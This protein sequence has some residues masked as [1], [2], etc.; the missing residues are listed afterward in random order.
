MTHDAITTSTPIGEIFEKTENGKWQPAV[1]CE[2]ADGSQAFQHAVE[3]FREW[4]EKQPRPKI[5]L[6]NGWHTITPELAE[7]LLICNV[8][9]RKLRWSEVYRYATSM[10]NKRW[11]KT[12]ETVIITD[13][14]DVEDAGHRLFACY[15]SNC[16]FE[17]YVVSDVPHDDQLFAYIDNGASR[18]GEDT[19]TAAG[20]N[21]LSASLSA[22]IKSYA[23]R[24]DEGA[25]VFN[26]RPSMVKIDNV[27]IL[28]YA[29]QNPDLMEMAHLCR[30]LY[31]GQIHRLDHRNLTVFLAWKIKQ[32]YGAQTLEDFMTLLATPADE[33]LA[34]QPGHPV[35]ALLNRL[36]Q[37]QTAK[38]VAPN[39][40]KAKFRLNDVQ[41]LGLAMRAFN[42]WRTGASVRRIDPRMDDPFPKIER[43]DED[44]QHQVPA[45]AQ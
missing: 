15:F 7:Q 22:I 24:Y 41:I 33:L 14:G 28:D 16:S 23:I 29:R 36:D 3:R 45:A 13:R 19:L 39:S 37:H 20:V 35:A 26:G 34:A 1:K 10:C 43:E 12:G 8:R 27:D 31:P 11:K 44:D 18:S 25:L 2:L 4:A 32:A 38:I 9:N 17:T 21:G 30:D 6:P 42:F 40:A 5:D